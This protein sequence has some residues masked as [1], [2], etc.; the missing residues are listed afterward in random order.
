MN[1]D[2]VKDLPTDLKRIVVNIL[3]LAPFWYSAIYLFDYQLIKTDLTSTFIIS[4]CLSFITQLILF[5]PVSIL[6][7][8]TFD[9]TNIK[10]FIPHILIELNS[11]FS[12]VLLCISIS[13]SINTKFG[14][15]YNFVRQV[16]ING[17]LFIPIILVIVVLLSIRKS[18]KT[19]K[20]NNQQ[21][22]S[23]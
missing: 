14:H 15:F 11:G 8:T 20:Q 6:I 21:C 5:I 9:G 7:S 12:I 1:L 19:H 3:F 17:L 4:F 2:F 18:R 13:F 16:F 23:N 22:N 10:K